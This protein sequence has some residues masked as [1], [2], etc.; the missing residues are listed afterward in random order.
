MPEDIVQTLP[1]DE[2]DGKVTDEKSNIEEK[3]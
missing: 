2:T 3:T 1:K